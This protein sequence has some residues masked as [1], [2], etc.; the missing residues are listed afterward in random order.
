MFEYKIF[1]K[2]KDIKSASLSIFTISDLSPTSSSDAK[3]FNENSLYRYL[4]LTSLSSGTKQLAK[5]FF[6]L[7]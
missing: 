7:G 4:Q 2:V 6:L 5:I 3:Q 1:T